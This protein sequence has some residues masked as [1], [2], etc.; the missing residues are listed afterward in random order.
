MIL[1]VLFW[2]RTLSNDIEGVLWQGIL[3]LILRVVYLQN[4]LSSDTEGVLM[5]G[6]LSMIF[7]KGGVSNITEIVL[8]QGNICN[9][10]VGGIL[11]RRYVSER[12]VMTKE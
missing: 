10:S 7:L 4:S 12:F 1:R 9:N 11:I 6:V 2:Q 3:L 5:Q 8:K